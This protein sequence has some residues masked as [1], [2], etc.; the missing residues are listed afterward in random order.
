[1]IILDFGPPCGIWG[2]LLTPEESQHSI[3][4]TWTDASRPD[5]QECEPLQ[6]WWNSQKTLQSKTLF[7]WFS[8]LQFEIWVPIV[9]LI[10][11]IFMN[12]IIVNT[13]TYFNSLLFWMIAQNVRENVSNPIG[14][15]SIIMRICYWLL[16]IM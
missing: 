13:D 16:C 10:C 12:T 1:M 11:Y 8:L 14:Q 7:F 3:G 2:P 6:K 9:V 15:K 4:I 5:I